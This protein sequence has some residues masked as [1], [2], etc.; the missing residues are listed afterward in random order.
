MYLQWNDADSGFNGAG[1]L[2][3]RNNT[4]LPLSLSR[5]QCRVLVVTVE[6][7]FEVTYTKVCCTLVFT[8]YVCIVLILQL[9]IYIR[10]RT[11]HPP[12]VTRSP[13]YVQGD[14][15]LTS[16]SSDWSFSATVK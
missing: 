2:L 12:S 4:V 3:P 15:K 8:T 14:A 1:R 13:K 10:Q 9:T 5:S 11:R 7:Y 16:Y 6:L